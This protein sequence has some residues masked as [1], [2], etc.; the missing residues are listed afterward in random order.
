MFVRRL[1]PGLQAIA[2]ESK[3]QASAED[4]RVLRVRRLWQTVS[5]NLDSWGVHSRTIE[6]TLPESTKDAKQ[7]LLG[8][9]LERR[10][11]DH[12]L[13][14]KATKDLERD[15]LPGWVCVAEPASPG[16]E[17][18]VSAGPMGFGV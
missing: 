1:F 13:G 4:R 6:Q 14:G 10:G 11:G 16:G 18:F 5:G 15:G 8:K 12:V 17:P 2:P 3:P 7:G 9:P